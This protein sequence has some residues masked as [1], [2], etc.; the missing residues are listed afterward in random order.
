METGMKKVRIAAR[1]S[2]PCDSDGPAS[3]FSVSA[4]WNPQNVV[5]PSRAQSSQKNSKKLICPLR[6]T[7]SSADINITKRTHF[8]FRLMTIHQPL[9]PIQP[10]MSPKNEPIFPLGSRTAGPTFA[11][12]TPAF[13][14]PGFAF[15]LRC[16][17]F[18]CIVTRFSTSASHR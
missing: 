12:R 13:P 14:V 11:R 2:C 8:K 3:V 15:K 18:V 16:V 10:S 7:T 1:A 9:T 6:G 17:A 4:S 5:A